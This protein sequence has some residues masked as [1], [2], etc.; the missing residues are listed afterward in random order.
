LAIPI[1]HFSFLLS[2]NI[3][4]KQLKEGGF[5]FGS[6][7]KGTAHLRMSSRAVREAF[8]TA[9]VTSPLTSLETSHWLSF[10]IQ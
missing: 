1:S 6:E 5:P 8:A 4:Q 10:L 7:F 2:Q 9:T 3:W